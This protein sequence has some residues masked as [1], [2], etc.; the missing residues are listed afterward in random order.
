MI[1]KTSNEFPKEE[2]YSLT[3][4][5][6]RSSRSIGAQIAEAWGKRLYI[7]HFVSKLTDAEAELNE[8]QH[9]IDIAY[10]CQYL[11]NSVK[12]SLLQQCHAI[13]TLLGGMIKKANLFCK[14]A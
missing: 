13:R 6:R 8:T 9:W 3:D 7:R 1:Y 5:M 11:P 4:Q 12:K 2:V 14:R 10:R